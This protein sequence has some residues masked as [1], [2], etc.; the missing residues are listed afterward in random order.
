[1]MNTKLLGLL[2]GPGK[3]SMR[4]SLAPYKSVLSESLYHKILTGIYLGKHQ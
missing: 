2:S 3:G 4:A 1:M